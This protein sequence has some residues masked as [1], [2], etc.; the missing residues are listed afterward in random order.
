MMRELKGNLLI[1]SS[2]FVK[3]NGCHGGFKINEME[4]IVEAGEHADRPS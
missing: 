2:S 4:R 3:R 1:G